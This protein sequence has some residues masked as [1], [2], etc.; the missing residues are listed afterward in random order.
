MKTILLPTDFS[1]NAKHAVKY[2]Y[3]LAK[4]IKANVAL[5]N[6]LIIPAEMPQAGFVVWPMGEYDLL[7][8]ESAEELKKLKA[9]LSQDKDAFKPLISCYNEVGTTADVVNAI[10]AK[11]KIDMVVMGTHGSSGLSS[12]LLGN[13]SRMLIDNIS[14]PLLIVPAQATDAPVKKIAFATDFKHPEMDLESIYDLIPLAKS[15]KAEI[16]L[17]H[18]SG[19]K[20]QTP[21][22]SK[23]IEQFLIGV[24]D[25]TDFPYIS[26]RL[27]K[28]DHT[29]PGLDWLCEHGQVDMLAMV[30]RPHNFFDNLIKGSYTQKIAAHISIPLLVFPV[31]D[32][33]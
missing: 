22:F 14:K 27:V 29:E 20:D 33:G 9:E 11:K 1:E 18:I 2:G 24:T 16:L 8:D 25:K 31:R 15:L 26:Y 4:R 10:I 30:H 3:D 5:C 7:M 19:E 28:N 21:E 12:F 23:W 6:A 32:E 13:H 17:T